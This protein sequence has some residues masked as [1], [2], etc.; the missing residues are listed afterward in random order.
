MKLLVLGGSGQVGQA[1]LTEA[2]RRGSA[3]LGTFATHP[4]PGLVAW[5]GSV[6]DARA[7]IA[8]FQPTLVVYASAW[9]AVDACEADPERATVINAETPVAV[10]RALPPSAR[11][12]FLS[13][14][15][16]FDGTSGPYGEDDPVNPLSAY[17]RTKR[18]AEVGIL[19]ARPDALIIRTTV[20]FGPDPQNKNFV[21]QLFRNLSAG[22]GMRVPRDQVSSPTYAPD[23]AAAALGLAHISAD[24]I[25]HVAGPRIVDRYQFA[26]EAADVLALPAALLEPVATADLKQP[27]LR[28]LQ[29]GLRINRLQQALGPSVMRDPMD[30]VREYGRLL[31][32]NAAGP[33][34]C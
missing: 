7:L 22:N 32:S 9:T 5:D 19:E 15:Y 25:W 4:H 12:V 26:V 10:A 11:L 3:A 20:V 6:P 29:A 34:A 21:A 1:F 27:A 13:T 16:V 30:A 17:G 2:E 23:L 24:G 14:E 31:R 8:G 33:G 18:A 28:P